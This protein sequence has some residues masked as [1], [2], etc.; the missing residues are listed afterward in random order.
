MRARDSISRS[1]G[2][3]VCLSVGRS[4]GRSVAEGSE[5]ATYGDRPCFILTWVEPRKKCRSRSNQIMTLWSIIHRSAT[6]PVRKSYQNLIIFLGLKT[7]CKTSYVWRVDTLIE[8][9]HHLWG[10]N[11]HMIVGTTFLV[12]KTWMEKA[13]VKPNWLVI[14]RITPSFP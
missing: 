11:A 13:L 10:I 6:Q 4:V 2:W 12:K 14:T 7:V 1:V 9:E 3:S 5:H 8:V